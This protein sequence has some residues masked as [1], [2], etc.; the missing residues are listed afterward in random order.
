[1]NTKRE[2]IKALENLSLVSQIGLAMAIPIF[3]CIWVGNYLDNKF[4][5]SPLFLFIFIVLGVGAAFS[6]LYKL[7]FKNTKGRK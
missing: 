2:W 7:T 4:N 3:G 5:K 6:N 1:M